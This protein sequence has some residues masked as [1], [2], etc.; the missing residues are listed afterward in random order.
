MTSQELKRL[1]DDG[2]SLTLVD[3]QSAHSYEHRHIPG[4]V[5]VPATASAEECEKCLPDKDARIVVYG[6][7]DELGN[8][9][10]ATEGLKKLGYTNVDRLEGEMM[11]WMEAGFAVEGGL[12]S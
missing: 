12:V 3:L 10:E 5:N 8:G 4:A 6:Q 1:L 11:G 7:Y 2:A 9:G